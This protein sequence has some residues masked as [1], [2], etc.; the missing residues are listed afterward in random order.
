MKMITMW[1]IVSFKNCNEIVNNKMHDANEWIKIKIYQ[2]AFQ[3]DSTKWNWRLPCVPINCR[4]FESLMPS[5]EF[6]CLHHLRIRMRQPVRPSMDWTRVLPNCICDR[7][8]CR[9]L[10]RFSSSNRTTLFRL[11]SRVLLSSRFRATDAKRKSEY[12]PLWWFRPTQCVESTICQVN[13]RSQWTYDSVNILCPLSTADWD[14]LHG[15][16]TFSKFLNLDTTKNGLRLFEN[17]CGT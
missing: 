7:C 10:A 6:R 12:G 8:V 15:V 4:Q 17:H 3:L 16:C 13:R 5:R 2:G 11:E 9:R 1:V 14:S